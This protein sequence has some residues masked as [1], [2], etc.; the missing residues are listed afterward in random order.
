ML[1]SQIRDNGFSSSL[2][3]LMSSVKLVKFKYVSVFFSFLVM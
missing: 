2:M 1:S 3:Y